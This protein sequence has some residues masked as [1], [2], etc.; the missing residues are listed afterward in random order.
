[1]SLDPRPLLAPSWTEVLKAVKVFVN[2]QFAGEWGNRGEVWTI[3]WH[4][5]GS[6]ENVLGVGMVPLKASWNWTLYLENKFI[7][8]KARGHHSW[9]DTLDEAVMMLR[10]RVDSTAASMSG[11]PCR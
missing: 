4:S 7:S 3:E 9:C 2:S 11:A 6:G 1:M 8:V 5:F 10:S